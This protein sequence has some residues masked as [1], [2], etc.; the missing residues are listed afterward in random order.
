MLFD[1]RVCAERR[2][3]SEAAEVS[4][5]EGADLLRSTNARLPR[6]FLKASGSFVR[7]S[8]ERERISPRRPTA[9]YRRSC[10]R[11]FRT[12]SR[13]KADRP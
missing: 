11:R 6:R 4:A 9:E 8:S 5:R 1:L 10:R 3:A 13:S 12:T 7:A 2:A